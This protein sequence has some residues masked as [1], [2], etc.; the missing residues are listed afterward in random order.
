MNLFMGSPSRI[1]LVG[2]MERMN[3]KEKKDGKN[4]RKEESRRDKRKEGVKILTKSHS[5]NWIIF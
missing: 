1:A 5:F 4:G 2:R 3:K